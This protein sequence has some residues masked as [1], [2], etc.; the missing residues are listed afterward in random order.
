MKNC[1][2][3]CKELL[4][5]FLSVFSEMKIKTVLDDEVEQLVSL[6]Q[7]LVSF[8][9]L[10]VSMDYK[11]SLMAWNAY[12]KLTT[13]YQVKLSY[14]IDF[15][16]ATEKVSS[17]IAR[18]Y[19]QLRTILSSSQENKDVVK[20]TMKVV[21][22]LKVPQ[23]VSAQ[24]VGQSA[25]FLDVLQ[26]LICGL[27]DL[28]TWIP[29][30]ARNNLT[31]VILSSKIKYIFLEAASSQEPF[32]SFLLEH[33]EGWRPERSPEDDAGALLVMTVELLLLR[34][35]HHQRLFEAALGLV[36]SGGCCLTRPRELEGRQS[37]G[38]PLQR[39]GWYCWTLCHCA[40]YLATL[41]KEEFPEVESSL[42]L[43]LLSPRSSLVT[44]LLISDIW[45]FLARFS[46]SRLCLAH[47]KT[48]KSARD[49]LQTRGCSLTVVVVEVLLQRL[50]AFL[51][52]SHLSQW[53]A[54][55]GVEDPVEE[56]WEKLAAG[57]Y[58]PE[59]L[60]NIT[61]LTGDTLQALPSLSVEE[62]SNILLSFHMIVQRN[63]Y[64]PDLLVPFLSIVQAAALHH[65]SSMVA[66]KLLNDIEKKSPFLPRSLGE[67]GILLQISSV[68]RALN[69]SPPELAGGLSS[70]TMLAE[71][72][73]G[74]SQEKTEIFNER[75]KLKLPPEV[76]ANTPSSES[77]ENVPTPRL[78][79]E[80]LETNDIPMKSPEPTK[81]KRRMSEETENIELA[82]SQLEVAVDFLEVHS[83]LDLK[84]FRDSIEQQSKKIQNT[85]E[86]IL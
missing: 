62:T 4:Q 3:C 42:L 50:A 18:N 37:R 25:A 11:L 80:T 71:C 51:T 24:S 59:D 34:P 67:S 68:C 12:L 82:V 69:I 84:P 66:F 85:L 65:K 31:S 17:E 28:P 36:S 77:S 38:R 53:E 35:D 61:G 21:Q 74:W 22:F 48:L 46:T 64:R 30:V 75:A 5:T 20:V 76:T 78:P 39:V 73:C 81:R 1:F 19:R 47:M 16:L 32:I 49:Q 60:V 15:S 58:Q 33:L 83:S 13:K 43:S 9:E 40:A 72:V 70:D 7:V 54:L 55:T 29:E 86:K 79:C 8:H 56:L 63:N 27:P 10:L 14:K 45:C 2:I 41:D 57:G 44:L 6:T 52:P 26:Q 23:S